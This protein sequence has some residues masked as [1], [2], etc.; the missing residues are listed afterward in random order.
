[1]TVLESAEDGCR[2]PF[3]MGD[4]FFLVIAAA[5]VEEGV[6]VEGPEPLLRGRR[7]TRRFVLFFTGLFGVE[8]EEVVFEVEVEAIWFEEDFFSFFFG[9]FELSFSSSASSSLLLLLLL[10]LALRWSA[11]SSSSSS[12]SASFPTFPPRGVDDALFRTEDDE[13]EVEAALA[14]ILLVSASSASSLLLFFLLLFSF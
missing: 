9:C 10:L 13:V 7:S 5:V 2:T 1:M 14:A 8:M 11:S 4:V 3:R 6:V 12:F